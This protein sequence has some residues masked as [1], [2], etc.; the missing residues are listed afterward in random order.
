MVPGGVARD[1]GNRIGL[2]SVHA[3]MV[4]R[5]D[6]RLDSRAQ[7]D[8]FDTLGASR[9]TSV[10][11]FGTTV[12][13]TCLGA[14]LGDVLPLVVDMVIR[15]RMGAGDLAAVKD[16]CVQGIESLADDPQERVS[17]NLRAAH[18]PSPIN[19]SSLGTREGIDAI[20][21]AELAPEWAK[22]AVPGGSILAIAGDV[23][24]ARIV[25]MVAK[26]TEGWTGSALPIA[27][28]APGP[29]GYHHEEDDTDQIH[30]AVAYDGPAETS[31]DAWMERL[32]T[33]VLSGGMS[34]RLFSEIREKRSLCYSVHAGYAG[35][36][37]FGRTVAYAGTTPERAQETLDLLLA[38]LRRIR[39]AEGAVTE[40]E[41]ERARVGMV[42]RLVFAAESTGA[43]ASAMAG[44]IRKL[45]RARSMEDMVRHINAVTVEGLNAYLRRT[46]D[47]GRMTVATIGPAELKVG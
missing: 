38:E 35:D 13:M 45:G 36:T 43:R 25:E 8:A 14:R 39:T 19:R 17:V 21:A 11:T 3:E 29:R 37:N 28:G 22:R 33:A 20:A 47:L 12:G 7:A 40:E 44:D 1:P 6:H 2:S 18:A 5:G 24:H 27:M 15:P 46:S 42:S 32:A 10:G 31:A 26:L 4:M 23:E 9:S 30:I 16:L 34:G 41:L